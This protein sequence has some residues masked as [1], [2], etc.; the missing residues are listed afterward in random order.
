MA[1][2]VSIGDAIMLSK[3]AMRLGQAFTS[4]RKSAQAEFL[5]VQNL[6]Y[7]LS[8]GLEMLAR[9]IPNRSGADNEGAPERVPEDK[10]TA[11]L[12]CMIANCQ[13]T[14]YHLESVVAK[15]T[16]PDTQIV[17]APKSKIRRWKDELFKNWKK[18]VWTTKGGDLGTLKL[19]LIAHIDGLNFAVSVLNRRQG[20]DVYEKVDLINTKLEEIYNWFAENLRDQKTSVT[21]CQI[22]ISPDTADDKRIQNMTF[23]VYREHDDQHLLICP[24]AFFHD[25]WVE[26]QL[27]TGDSGIFK[28]CCKTLDS[29][30]GEP[31]FPNGGPHSRGLNF[32]CDSRNTPFQHQ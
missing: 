2:S 9:Q 1:F 5:E 16:V 21:Q 24:H 13:E 3:I 25:D 26:I 7:A 18:I 31:V 12:N 23:A 11:E 14:L 4:G 20:N 30:T 19:T 17:E 27:L 6:L 22:P 28:C 10:E 29:S 15:Y 8:K 32:S